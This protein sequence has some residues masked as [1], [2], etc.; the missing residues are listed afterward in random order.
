MTFFIGVVSQK[1]GVGK[2]TIS[3]IV[4]TVYAHN[5]WLVKIADMDTKQGTCTDWKRR[6]DDN[7]IEPT[8]HVEPFRR[9]S[10]AVRVA[11]DYHMMIFDG[12]PYSTQSTLEISRI[13][14]LI[15]LPTSEGIEA[16]KPTILLA[17]EIKKSGTP[18]ENIGI[19]FCSVSDSEAMIA[20]A[21]E[22]VR[23][24]GYH[25]FEGA[26]PSRAGYLRTHETGRSLIEASH[27][28]LRG[29]AQSLAAGITKKIDSMV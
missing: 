28:S 29:K 27:P 4:A 20:E 2:S 11:N 25:A 23:Q 9:V 26:I 12:A 19:A 1:G 22:Y 6:R 14:N 24:A 5:D 3:R 10:D 15:I 13:S 17:H 16:L 8:I 7:R 21:R 18:I